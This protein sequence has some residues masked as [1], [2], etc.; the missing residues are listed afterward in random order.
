MCQL[1]YQVLL[2]VS[3]LTKPL[4]YLAKRHDLKLIQHLYGDLYFPVTQ[5]VQGSAS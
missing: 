5:S 3:A 4:K 2:P 1:Q